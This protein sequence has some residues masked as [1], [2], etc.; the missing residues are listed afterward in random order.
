M[1]S[2][3]QSSPSLLVKSMSI[4]TTDLSNLISQGITQ[5]NGGE[6]D[7]A[8]KTLE[9]AYELAPA[10]ITVNYFLA[11]IADDVGNAAKA[12]FHYN[13]VISHDPTNRQAY[14]QLANALHLQGKKWKTLSLLHKAETQF[15]EDHEIMFRRGQ[16]ASRLIPG[17]HLPMLAD[18]DR[19][20]A[21]EEAIKAKVKPGD[22]V[23]DIGTGSGLLAMMAARAGAE[24]V[25]A[26]EMEEVLAELATHIIELNGLKDKIT[27]LNKHS[28]QL[29]IGQDL[30]QKVD[31]LIAEVFDRALVGED[32]LSTIQH[33]W[34]NLLKEDAQT[35][36][37]G[38]SLYGA[39]IECPHL[40]QFHNINSV[41]GFDLSPM[42]VLAQP[43]TYKDAQINLIDSEN[44]RVLSK[45]FSIKDFRFDKIPNLNFSSTSDVT[46]IKDGNA[47]TISMWFELK[48]APGVFFSTQDISLNNHW[49]HA[50]Q[51][52]L[53][54]VNCTSGQTVTLNTKYQNLYKYFDF[55]IK[56]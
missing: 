46:I 42:N 44:H 5:Y 10:N 18:S 37:E 8:R 17:W 30:P 4:D 2:Q 19:N 34:Q 29:T 1:G 40:Q 28:S 9:S 52:L 38:A 14:F 48:L 26:C 12:E 51:I 31:V 54:Q 23:L 45:S 25:Y 15:P 24:H 7:P 27:I 6:I 13:C 39:L 41:N 11:A 36:P 3:I 16:Y 47:D 43:L 32:A 53:E 56:E 33:A 22:I 50:S 55:K 20:D 49:R 35:I 21:F